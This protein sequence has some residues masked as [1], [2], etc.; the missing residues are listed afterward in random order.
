MLTINLLL[1][2]MIEL[3]S[4]LSSPSFQGKTDKEE[5]KLNL[6]KLD[7]KLD[8]ILDTDDLL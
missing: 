5:V 1:A 8:K 3:S 6:D 4:S 2:V 7:E